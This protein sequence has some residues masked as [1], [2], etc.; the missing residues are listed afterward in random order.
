[1]SGF[2]RVFS[3]ETLVSLCSPFVEDFS[4]EFSV[5]AEGVL[6]GF[7]SITEDVV[8]DFKSSAVCCEA[9]S[10]SCVVAS[11][12]LDGSSVSCC[13]AEFN[14]GGEGEEDGVE[15]SLGMISGSGIVLPKSFIA[16]SL[17]SVISL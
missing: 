10:S 16:G 9:S 1:L 17:T 15:D 14:S 4:N 8:R 13:I 5:S 7:S 3:S 12:F 11:S 6:G 2:F